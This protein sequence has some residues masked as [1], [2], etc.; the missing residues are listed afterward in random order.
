MLH[1]FYIQKSTRKQN[2][3]LFLKIDETA[4]MC[5]DFFSKYLIK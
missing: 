3:V 2:L 1:G 5:D 4:R